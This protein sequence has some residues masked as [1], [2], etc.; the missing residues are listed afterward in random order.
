M[1]FVEVSETVKAVGPI[2][3]F[4]IPISLILAYIVLYKAIKLKQKML[5]IFV[6]ALFFYTF[7]LLSFPD[8]IYILAIY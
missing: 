8:R 4:Y 6:L 1:L 3:F 2:G 7:T 5:Y